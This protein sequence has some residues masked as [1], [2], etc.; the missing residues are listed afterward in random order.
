MSLKEQQEENKTSTS[1]SAK[2]GLNIHKWDKKRF[3][4]TAISNLTLN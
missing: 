3:Q 1:S 4:A 2:I